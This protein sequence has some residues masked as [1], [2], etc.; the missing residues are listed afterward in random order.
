[1]NEKLWDFSSLKVS[2]NDNEGNIRKIYL[3]YFTFVV[4]RWQTKRGLFSPFVQLN[5]NLINWWASCMHKNTMGWIGYISSM[6]IK[7]KKL[8]ININCTGIFHRI[9]LLVLIHVVVFYKYL[10]FAFK[11]RLKGLQNAVGINAIKVHC[12]CINT[13]LFTCN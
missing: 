13:N 10:F 6:E 5:E 3:C 2:R 11:S 7:C 1:M 4:F 12:T 8:W 9:N